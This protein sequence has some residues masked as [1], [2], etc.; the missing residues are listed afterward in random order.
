LRPGAERQI[1]AV[2]GSEPIEVSGMNVF[3]SYAREDSNHA[4]RLYEDFLCVPGVTPWLDSR[5][6]LPGARWKQEV[7]RALKGSDLF[8][9]LLSSRS[10]SKAGFVQKEIGEALDKLSKFP[11]DQIYLI[12]ARLEECE[13]KHPELSELQWVDLFPDWDAGVRQIRQV[14]GT[15]LDSALP[16]SPLPNGDDASDVVIESIASQDMFVRRLRARG[17]LRG[18]DAMEVEL[19]GVSMAKTNLSGANFV[20]CILIDCDLRNCNLRGANFEGA[21]FRDSRLAGADLWGAN[22]WGADTRGI[23][24][25]DKARLDHTNFFRTQQTKSQEAAVSRAPDSLSLGDYGTFV[26]FFREQVGLDQRAMAST[27]VWLNHRYFLRMF[28]GKRSANRRLR[29]LRLGDQDDKDN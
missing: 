17:E 13:P 6:L 19:S 10:V 24:D 29:N 28:G 16:A 5:N 1:V 21:V 12:P 9:V 22:F 23:V 14:I 4:N 11:P 25:F 27:F 3:I 15:H 8:V 26:D 20:R 2:R 7:M 18:C